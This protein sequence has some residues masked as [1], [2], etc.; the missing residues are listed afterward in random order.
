[1]NLLITGYY[2]HYNLGD[3]LFIKIASKI[4]KPNNKLNIS[5]TNILPI[6]KINSDN[7]DYDALI[8]FG[9]DVLNSYFLNKI[10]QFRETHLDTRLYAIGVGCDEDYEQITNKIYMFDYIIFRN[11]SDYEYFKDKIGNSF[12]EYAPDIIHTL[13]IPK[14]S[15]KHKIVAFFPAMP[16]YYH[17]PN[18]LEKS[19]IY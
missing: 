17:L 9:G 14:K 2:D 4:F 7:S 16:I 3:D 1:M 15:K 11:I 18:S 13:S 12:C 5:T 10:I 19:R 6:E 8:L